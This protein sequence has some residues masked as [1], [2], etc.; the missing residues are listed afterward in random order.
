MHPW[1]YW[2]PHTVQPRIYFSLILNITPLFSFKKQL[3][4][5]SKRKHLQF[6]WKCTRKLTFLHIY[7]YYTRMHKLIFFFT[8]GI[9]TSP[10]V[11]VN[12]TSFCL[13]CRILQKQPLNQTLY[14]WVAERQYDISHIFFGF[15]STPPPQKKSAMQS[16]QPICK[17]SY[18]ILTRLLT[19]HSSCFISPTK[20]IS[21]VQPHFPYPTIFTNNYFRRCLP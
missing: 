2:I 1:L 16:L 9:Q 8:R 18:Q 12:T 10:E 3:G 21:F 5:F 20:F 13:H 17:R 6:M 19:F 15:P 14:S 7:N 11:E 4:Q